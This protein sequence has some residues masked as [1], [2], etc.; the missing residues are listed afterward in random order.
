MADVRLS[1]IAGSSGLSRLSSIA[2]ADMGLNISA[3]SSGLIIASLSSGSS[4]TTVLDITVP[5]VIG[6][7]VVQGVG[8]Q[9]IDKVKITTD[10]GVLFDNTAGHAL[11]DS[12]WFIGAPV[13]MAGG[14]SSGF[15]ISNHSFRAE[16]LK[17]ELDTTSSTSTINIYGDA[18]LIT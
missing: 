5:L 15:S 8:A 2:L 18:E 16:S 13:K 11:D 17:I 12:N 14:G 6:F 3:A 4:L 9:T 1:T 10:Q 7:L